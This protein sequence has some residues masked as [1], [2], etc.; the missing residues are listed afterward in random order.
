MGI[1]DVHEKTMKEDIIEQLHE[2]NYT[3]TD[4]K[5]YGELKHKLAVIKAMEIDVSKTENEWF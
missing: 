1:A 2:L 5:S 4:G 3:K